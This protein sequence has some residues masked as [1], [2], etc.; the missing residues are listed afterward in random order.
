MSHRCV[1]LSNRL[2]QVITKNARNAEPCNNPFLSSQTRSKSCDFLRA[3]WHLGWTH[4]THRYLW[5]PPWGNL[6]VWKPMIYG[7]RSKWFRH[8]VKWLAPGTRHQALRTRHLVPIASYQE[9]GT[10]KLAPSAW[11]WL[12]RS[13]YSN[14]M[15][16][17]PFYGHVWPYMAI[18]YEC[19]NKLII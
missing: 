4:S 13:F 11:H 12:P 15:G 16:P 10:K 5:I 19:I 18:K 6:M 3:A 9:V 2:M 7:F 17:G 14:Y 1:P 8:R